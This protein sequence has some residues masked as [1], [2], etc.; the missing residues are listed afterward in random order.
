MTWYGDGDFNL[1]EYK[2]TVGLRT[3]AGTG[4]GMAVCA[5]LGL[6]ATSCKETHTV[7]VFAM[8]SMVNSAAHDQG[9]IIDLECVWTIGGGG[10]S[11]KMFDFIGIQHPTDFVFGMSNMC[12]YATSGYLAFAYIDSRHLLLVG[13]TG[14]DT[15]HIFD[16]VA[17]KFLGFIV[18]TGA[19]P[20]PRGIAARGSLVAVACYQVH[21]STIPLHERGIFPECDRRM[22]SCTDGDVRMYESYDAT[23][24]SLLRVLN[25]CVSHVLLK[26][27]CVQFSADGTILL[28]SG[29]NVIEHSVVHIVDQFHVCDGTHAGGGAVVA[30][31]KFDAQRIFALAVTNGGLVVSY[32]ASEG[33]HNCKCCI[34]SR[35]GPYGHF[36]LH[37]PLDSHVGDYLTAIEVV[38][39][40]GILVRECSDAVVQVLS[41]DAQVAQARRMSTLRVAWMS[42]VLRQTLCDATSPPPLDPRPRSKSRLHQHDD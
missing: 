13:D 8:G 24:W 25:T 33:K 16:V 31:S 23:T 2:P 28:V 39:N 36:G 32:M 18:G 10:G 7:A 38:P 35:G 15:I 11:G 27:L 30:L 12:G 6:L 14:N 19:I 3:R 34:A 1:N 17:R 20:G 37:T 40:V 9:T 42:V 4:C 21:F 5:P 22:T 41:T 29:V 26:P